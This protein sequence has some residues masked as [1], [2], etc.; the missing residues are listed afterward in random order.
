[1][2]T[3]FSRVDAERAEVDLLLSSKKFARTNNTGRFLSFVCEKYFE[4]S[5]SEIKEYS[6]AVEALGRPS[7][8]DPQVD[9]IVRVT[10]HNLRKQ[11]ELYYATEGASHPVHLYLPAGHYIPQFVRNEALASQRQ[12]SEPQAVID[13]DTLQPQ[14]SKDFLPN[15][16]VDAE[17]PQRLT[18]ERT[19]AKPR[20]QSRA[21]T[22][23]LAFLALFLCMALAFAYFRWTR[24]SKSKPRAAAS[25]PTGLHVSGSGIHALVGGDREAYV[26][27]GGFS[28]DRD[29]FCSGGEPFSVS[30]HAIQ[31][32]EDPQLFAAGRRGAFHCQYPVPPGTYE[33][34]L[35]FAETSGLQ[36]A[37]RNV[38]FS[39]NGGPSQNLDVVDDAGGDDIATTKVLTDVAPTTDG[40][41]HLDFTTSE[42]FLNAIE[43]LPG[44]PHH[45]LPV[46][47]VAGHA[48]FHD[49]AGNLWMPDRYHFGGRLSSFGGD[50]SKISDG[51]LYEWHRFGH[52]HYIVPVAIG[53][54]YTLKLYFLEHWFGVQNGG[55]GGAGSRVFD[56]SCNGSMLLKGFDI[57]RE[58]GSKP[59]VKS[60]E[61]IEP[62]PQGKIEIYFT[63]AVNY[64]SISAIEVIPE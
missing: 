27:R 43:I 55:I 12:D 38:A 29:K 16:P 11:L 25:S 41:I 1:M 18:V 56:V 15:A 14:L 20:V 57:L 49:S 7:D 23:V 13:A 17:P 31:G 37:S 51:Q 3:V 50:L 36:E 53:D 60:F 59:L 44:I 46:R 54:T 10:A 35:L 40:T 8:F 26:D 4:G 61:H 24:N 28:W 6:I 19:Q 2:G 39:V 48:S 64:P 21:R 30:G 63:P 22:A 58:A 33:L 45:M 42:A 34:H 47:I 62:T 9:C 5:T 32:T 52:F